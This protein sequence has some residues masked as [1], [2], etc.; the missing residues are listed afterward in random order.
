MESVGKGTS[1]ILLNDFLNSFIIKTIIIKINCKRITQRMFYKYQRIT[2]YQHPG[3][4]SIKKNVK[5]FQQ[6]H[7]HIKSIRQGKKERIQQDTE[8]YTNHLERQFNKD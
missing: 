4:T 8:I 3:F 6:M 1:P 2:L 7:A 5:T